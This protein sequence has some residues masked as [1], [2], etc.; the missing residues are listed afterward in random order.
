M[1]Q[2]HPSICDESHYKKL[3]LEYS[4]RLYRYLVY[5]Y[6]VAVDAEDITQNVFLKLWEDCSRFN[7]KNIKSLIFTMGKNMSINQIKKNKRGEGFV[8]MDKVLSN[9]ESQLEEK[10]FH[11]KLVHS[12]EQ[13]NENERLVFMMSRLEDLSYKEIANQLSISQKTVEK[14]MHSALKFL[15]D[16]LSVNLK[17]K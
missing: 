4:D 13:L 8:F 5:A 14:R 12:I 7:Q 1:N 17:K 16:R 9:P 15:H 11:Q 6:G 3:Y 10:E 2:T